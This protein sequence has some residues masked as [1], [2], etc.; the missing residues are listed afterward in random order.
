MQP[1]KRLGDML[2]E[3]GLI[4]E[5]QLRSALANQRQWGG[6]LGTNLIKM[7]F[8]EEQQL[9]KFLS[10]SMGLPAVDFS[11]LDILPS[12]V[13]LVKEKL[14]REYN[15]I[16]VGEKKE[17]NSEYLYLAMSDPT[18]LNAL[19]AITAVTRR[20]V[21]PVVASDGAILNA[22][23]FYYSGVGVKP[24]E[25]HT[26]TA[27]PEDGTFQDEMA[28]EPQAEKTAQRPPQ[29]PPAADDQ[30][31]MTDDLSSDDSIILFSG[32]GEEQISLAEKIGATQRTKEKESSAE[33]TKVDHGVPAEKPK[34]PMLAEGGDDF[35]ANLAD[36]R[37][38]AIALA[39][40]LMD[41]GVI[42]K[43]EFFRRYQHEKAKD[44]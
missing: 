24:T 32:D 22:I 14:A 40:V 29:P 11:T 44:K 7:G 15:V 17:G 34:P 27:V 38:M 4:D 26:R 18:N 2:I 42:S 5:Y 10:K 30:M 13:H 3:A 20:K 6:R 39:K 1:K 12:I 21:K 33:I 16:P 23:D 28:D 36:T 31:S 25:A 35:A 9:V 43:D 41:K 37:A 8:L 19:D